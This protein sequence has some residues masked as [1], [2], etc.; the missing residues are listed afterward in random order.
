MGPTVA[1]SKGALTYKNLPQ[2][3][4]PPRCNPQTGKVNFQFPNSRMITALD[5]S[6]PLKRR[7]I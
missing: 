4:K 1:R 5:F 7:P 3:H 2:Q 6:N